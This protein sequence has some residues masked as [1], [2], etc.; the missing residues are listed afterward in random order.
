MYGSE[1][2][3]AR[4]AVDQIKGNPYVFGCSNQIYNLFFKDNKPVMTSSMILISILSK[5][6]HISSTTISEKQ[7]LQSSL[8]STGMMRKP[9]L[10]IFLANIGNLLRFGLSSNHYFSGGEILRKLTTSKRGVIQFQPTIHPVIQVM[11]VA[12]LV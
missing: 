7:L 5:R 8:G 12:I 11:E 6:H 2:V 1:F 10:L 4:T 3:A 9:T